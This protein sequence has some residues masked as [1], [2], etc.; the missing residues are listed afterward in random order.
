MLFPILRSFLNFTSV[1]ALKTSTCHICFHKVFRIYIF[2]TLNIFFANIFSDMTWR[3][4]DFCDDDTKKSLRRRNEYQ[5][6][7]GKKRLHALYRER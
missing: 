4:I 2:Y 7:R 6:K 1:S 3:K 5:D